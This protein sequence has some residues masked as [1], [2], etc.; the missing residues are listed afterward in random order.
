M[1]LFQ[2]RRTEKYW[3][4]SSVRLFLF[5][6]FWGTKQKYI[7][8]IVMW[9]PLSKGARCSRARIHYIAAGKDDSWDICNNRIILSGTCWKY[10]LIRDMLKSDLG[11]SQE[12]IL[13]GGSRPLSKPDHHSSSNCWSTSFWYVHQDKVSSSSC[14]ICISMYISR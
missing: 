3:F 14:N 12:V 9:I 11:I 4:L 8:C 13:Q 2:E 10:H 7:A 1:T 5:S 6:V